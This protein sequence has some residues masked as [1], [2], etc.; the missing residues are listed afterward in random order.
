MVEMK[1][2]A[3]HFLV[4]TPGIEDQFFA[5]S[6]IYLYQHNAEGASGVAVNKPLKVKLGAVLR[7]LNVLSQQEELNNHLVFAGGPISPEQGLIIY[8]KV[9]TEKPSGLLISS[10]KDELIAISQGKG[11]E[12]FLLTLG[13]SVWESGQ[14]EEEIRQNTWLI[15]PFHREL[16]FSYNV[17]MKWKA[18]LASI[19]VNLSYFSG[20]AGRA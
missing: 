14:L 4:A 12:S 1:S 17:G 15:A 7:Q 3:N 11:P 5:E 8:E 6:V 10:S 13:H 16:L 2:L 19:G 20:E 18:A 9:L